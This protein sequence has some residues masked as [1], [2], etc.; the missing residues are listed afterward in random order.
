[1]YNLSEQALEQLMMRSTECYDEHCS[2]QDKIGLAREL[3]GMWGDELRQQADIRHLLQK[4]E[5]SIKNS[6]EA[7]LDF[8]IINI[9]RRCDEEEGGSCCGAGLENK[10]DTLLLL[11]NLLVGVFLPENHSRPDSCY[12][13]TEKGCRLRVRL[14]LCVDFLCAKITGALRSG[15]FTRLQNISGDELVTGFR[16]YDAIKRFLRHKGLEEVMLS[17]KDAKRTKKNRM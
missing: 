17:T 3:Y 14:V 5:K 7:M 15:E 10:F 12:L 2:I 13:L 16:L 6:R 4:L 9:C 1:M 8:G 11:M